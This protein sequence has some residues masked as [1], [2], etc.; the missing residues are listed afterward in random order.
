MKTVGIV[1]A[2]GYAGGELA[3]LLARHPHV[4]IGCVVSNTFAGKPFSTAFPGLAGTEV[5]ALTCQSQDAVRTGLAVDFVFLAQENG[6]AMKV[7]GE[8]LKL[9]RRVVDISADFRLRDI[10]TYE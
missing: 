10:E 6:A 5:G 9:G 7:V 1:G 2:S 8:L 3:R 4:R